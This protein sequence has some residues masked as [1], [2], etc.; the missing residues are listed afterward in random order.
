MKEF[1]VQFTFIHHIPAIGKYSLAKL[2]HSNV[3]ESIFGRPRIFT[4]IY[5]FESVM[6]GKK[7]IESYTTKH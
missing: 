6:E 4:Q 7:K 5:T 1:P 3:L 2:K